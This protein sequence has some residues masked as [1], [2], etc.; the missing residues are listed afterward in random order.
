RR[1]ADRPREAAVAL[2]RRYPP[3][4]ADEALGRRVE[5]LGAHARL[6]ARL[7]LFERRDEDLARARHLLDLRKR[8]LDD[9]RRSL[10]RAP[11]CAPLRPYS[12]SSSF[13]VATVA[14]MW[15]CTSSGLRRPSK[16]RSSP[17]SS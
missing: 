14:R 3:A 5:R 11:P 16:C 1:R 7:E 10:A 17:A 4:R 6:D 15:L 2:E 9:H 12:S 13:S 8:L